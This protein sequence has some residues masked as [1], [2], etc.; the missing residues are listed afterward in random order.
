MESADIRVI[1]LHFMQNAD[2]IQLRKVW[3]FDDFKW[4]DKRFINQ[5]KKR[6]A[7]DQPMSIYEAA[8]WNMENAAGRR[9]RFYNYREIADMLIPY[10]GEMGYTHVELMPITEY[11]Y[12]L[13]W[14]YQVT[15]Y[16]GVTSRYGTQKISII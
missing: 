14:G 8:S 15:G 13:S 1:P 6:Q 3:D 9:E 10:L 4:S 12:D 5:R 2:Q 16:Y 7:L 11:P